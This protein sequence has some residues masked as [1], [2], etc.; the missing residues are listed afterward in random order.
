MDGG[1]E[2]RGIEETGLAMLKSWGLSFGGRGGNQ[3]AE[4]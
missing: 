4:D 2:V 1:E 3:I